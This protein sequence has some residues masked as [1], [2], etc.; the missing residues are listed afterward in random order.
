M[1]CDNNFYW[2]SMRK[3]AKKQHSTIVWL[4]IYMQFSNKLD[5]PLFWLFVKKHTLLYC[6]QKRPN[7]QRKQDA[8]LIIGRCW[9]V[10]IEPSFPWLVQLIRE[11]PCSTKRLL[12]AAFSGN[13]T[14]QLFLYEMLG[15]LG[16]YG[17]LYDEELYFKTIQDTT[18]CSLLHLLESGL[19]VY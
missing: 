5:M 9:C 18:Y 7:K 16:Y 8:V 17:L 19:T 11:E 6:H 14:E 12:K 1:N 15:P 13:T 4:P 2:S 3:H 10:E